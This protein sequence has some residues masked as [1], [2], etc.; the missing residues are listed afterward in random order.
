M[1]R[2]LTGE[3]QVIFGNT[4]NTSVILDELPYNYNL[5]FLLSSVNCVG[6]SSPVTYTINIGMIIDSYLPVQ[7]KHKINMLLIA[8]KRSYYRFVEILFMS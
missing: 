3:P 7:Y 2:S 5:L 1:F 4:S 6:S 8:L